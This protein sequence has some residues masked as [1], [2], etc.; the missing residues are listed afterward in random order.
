MSKT[1][2]RQ[3][4]NQEEKHRWL[5]DTLFLSS[6]YGGEYQFHFRVEG[7]ELKRRLAKYSSDHFPRSNIGNTPRRYRHEEHKQ[8]RMTCKTALAKY[9]K[10]PEYDILVLT[11]PLKDYWD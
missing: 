2:R 10:D 4:G 1:I 9:R 5:R 7:K 8:L 3:K 6:K 11:K